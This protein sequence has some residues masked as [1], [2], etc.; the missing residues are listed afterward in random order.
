MA[1]KKNRPTIVS[2]T[3]YKVASGCGSLFATLN[4]INENPFEMFLKLGSQGTCVSSFM[5]ALGSLIS[6]SMRS[7]VPLGAFIRVLSTATCPSA[8][9]EVVDII[10]TE[11]GF[12]EVVDVTPSCMAAL[13]QLLG[14]LTEFPTTNNQ[15]PTSPL[16]GILEE[17]RTG[18]GNV[19]VGC[20]SQN[21]ALARVSVEIGA[22][23]SCSAAI[24]STIAKCIN[25]ALAYG[26]DPQEI[27]KA[28][29]GIHCPQSNHCCS[30][31]LDAIG[32]MISPEATNA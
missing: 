7:G 4:E 30:S 24:G 11:D 1:L 18:C 13:G 32:Q 9:K 6:A 2:G 23:G 15:S 19:A 26:V 16:A 17:T 8:R 31:C 22:A 21:G 25:I 28:L 27:G 20:F 12:E 14:E 10:H 29:K 3:T 5:A